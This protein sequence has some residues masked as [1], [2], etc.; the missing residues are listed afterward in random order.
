[1][2]ITPID[3]DT[4]FGELRP[5]LIEEIKFPEGI[6]I[7]EFESELSRGRVIEDGGQE[8]LIYLT[9]VYDCSRLI[10]RIH[11]RL[12]RTQ[13]RSQLRSDGRLYSGRQVLT[14]SG[15]YP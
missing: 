6:N 5:V 4:E 11:V 9:P 12:G 15:S 7:L 10:I 14:S 13:L 1:M 2:G 3:E 8:T